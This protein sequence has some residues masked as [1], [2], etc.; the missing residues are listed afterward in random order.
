MQGYEPQML[1]NL[2]MNE[3]IA[4]LE[5]LRPVLTSRTLKHLILIIEATFAMSGRVTMKLWS[6]NQANI[7][8]D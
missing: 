8:L 6:Q 2:T 3:I 1:P 4:T 5:V 7:R